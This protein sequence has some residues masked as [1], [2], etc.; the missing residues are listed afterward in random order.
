MGMFWWIPALVPLIGAVILLISPKLPIAIWE[1]AK[2]DEEIEQSWVKF[3]IYM[4]VNV[5]A[6]I[7]F[8]WL[9]W[10]GAVSKTKFNEVWNMRITGLKYEMEW[11]TKETY[12]VEVDD[13][14][15]VDSDGNVTHHSHTE[16]RHRTD[17]H[18][19]YWTQIDEYGAASSIDQGVYNYWKSIWKNEQQTGI[20]NGSSAGFDRSIDGPIFECSWPGTFETIYPETEIHKYVNKIRVSHSVLKYGESDPELQKKYPRPV[21]QRNVSPVIVYG[22]SGVSGD[23]ELLLR[24]INADFGRRYEIH[25]MLV[26]F[27]KSADRS[28][29]QDI[30]KA[31]AG[32]NKNELVTFVS[33]DGKSVRW[34]DVHSWMD[35]T[36]LHATIRDELA[37]ETFS[38]DQYASLLRK[39][40]PKYWH[41]THFTPINA[42]LHVSIHPGWI[43][44][45]LLLGIITG[46]VSY[47]VIEKNMGDDEGGSGFYPY[48]SFRSDGYRSRS[49]YGR[50]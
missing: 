14:D 7:L 23:E 46:I 43:I 26:L 22:G 18:G 47:I 5:L 16:I 32:P 38:V 9:S 20:H 1:G 40:V 29:V 27:D 10:V 41:R 11:T 31:W 13:S 19:P 36:T 15:T 24:R 48:S 28:V 50:W 4:V 35:D 12:T 49:R 25:A 3:G 37:G 17:H 44:L 45:A 42:Y 33:L 39:Y 21:D 34:V 30:L 6:C 2:S 8:A